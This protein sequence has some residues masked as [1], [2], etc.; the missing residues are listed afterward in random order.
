MNS[1]IGVNLVYLSL[2]IGINYLELD[3]SLA[4][5]KIIR[6]NEKVSCSVNSTYNFLCGEIGQ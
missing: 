6:K 5:H 1:N 2:N 4:V 3:P